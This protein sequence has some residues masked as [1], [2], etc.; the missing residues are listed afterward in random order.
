MEG[1]DTDAVTKVQEKEDAFGNT[2][3]VERN[4][5]EVKDEEEIVKLWRQVDGK[6]EDRAKAR[7]RTAIS[8]KSL[9]H[10]LLFIFFNPLSIPFFAFFFLEQRIG[11]ALFM[12]LSSVFAYFKSSFFFA[13]VFFTAFD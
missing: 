3:S 5:T 13:M 12:Q 1:S 8:V 10:V 2:S 4:E 9:L 7:N 6:L 11:S